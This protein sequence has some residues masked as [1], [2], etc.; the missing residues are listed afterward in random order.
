M[1]LF[2]YLIICVKGVSFET[3][4]CVSPSCAPARATLR[5]GNCLQRA[6]IKGNKMV[7]GTVYK[8][9]RFIEQAVEELETFEQIMVEEMNY[10][11]ETYGKW[12]GT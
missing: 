5:T 1:S 4:Y 2:S 7:E 6:A 10:S 12:H 8:R 9:M 3:A 11:A